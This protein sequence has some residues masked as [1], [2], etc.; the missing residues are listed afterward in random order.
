MPRI[1]IQSH[2]SA[3]ERAETT[4]SERVVAANVNDPHYGAQ[5]LQRVRWATTDAEALESPAAGEHEPDEDTTPAHLRG[6][7]RSARN[8]GSAREAGSGST[9]KVRARV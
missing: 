3:G 8:R 6:L 2:P 7:R 9:K 5:L 4:L 1:I